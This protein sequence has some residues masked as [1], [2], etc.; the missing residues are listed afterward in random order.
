MN[1]EQGALRHPCSLFIIRYSIE[2]RLNFDLVKLPNRLNTVVSFK[3]KIQISFPN[4]RH[5]A[6]ST[7]VGKS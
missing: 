5:Q 3:N 7:L 2:I 4:P 6:A 1:K